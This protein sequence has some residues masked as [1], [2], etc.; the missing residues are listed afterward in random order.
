MGHSKD[1]TVF[2]NDVTAKERVKMVGVI[3]ISFSYSHDFSPRKINVIGNAESLG[4]NLNF[5]Q[6]FIW[7]SLFKS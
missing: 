6:W 1:G 7:I 3:M 5:L 4:F 2:M